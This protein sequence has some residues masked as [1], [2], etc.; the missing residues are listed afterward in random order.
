M[1]KITQQHLCVCLS[2][3]LC[4]CV[5]THTPIN[6]CI[7]INLCINIL[8]IHK[9]FL[10]VSTGA[11]IPYLFISKLFPIISL[12]FNVS[13]IPAIVYQEHYVYQHQY[14]HIYLS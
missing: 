14:S 8:Y 1:Y 5:Y 12:Q 2:V 4:M 6:L 11:F 10:F 9:R 3:S 7:R 13:P